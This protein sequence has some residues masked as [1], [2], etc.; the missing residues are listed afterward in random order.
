MFWPKQFTLSSNNCTY[1]RYEDGYYWISPEGKNH[2]LPFEHINIAFTPYSHIKNEM[3]T[4]YWNEQIEE[5]INET[6]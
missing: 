3:I 4:A 2:Y 5:I 1:H 6:S